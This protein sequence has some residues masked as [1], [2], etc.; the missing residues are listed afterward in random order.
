MKLITRLLVVAAIG[1]AVGYVLRRRR[2]SEWDP[3]RPDGT[4]G[5]ERSGLAPE[6]WGRAPRTESNGVR[7]GAVDE[8]ARSRDPGDR[9]QHKPPLPALGE[10]VG[11]EGPAGR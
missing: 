10:G 5:L 11:G 2:A 8:T 7:A 4:W 6:T 9:G 3:E 1:A